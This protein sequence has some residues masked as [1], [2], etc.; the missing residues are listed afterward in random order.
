M[1][2]S[3]SALVGLPDALSLGSLPELTNPFEPLK[4][5]LEPTKQAT[6]GLM[7]SVGGLKSLFG[8]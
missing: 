2:M 7:T 4:G 8:V 1:P 5:A 6:D 3:G